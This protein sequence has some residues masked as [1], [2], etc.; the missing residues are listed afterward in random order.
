[1][2]SRKLEGTQPSIH[3]RVAATADADGNTSWMVW[4]WGIGK[5]EFWRTARQACRQ[6]SGARLASARARSYGRRSRGSATSEKSGHPRTDGSS[7][8]RSNLSDVHDDLLW[9]GF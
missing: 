9:A 2:V 7:P 3:Q 5:Q 1:M 4:N 6:C 8:V